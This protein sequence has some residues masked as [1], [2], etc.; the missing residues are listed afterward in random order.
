ML[1]YLVP[2]GWSSWSVAK[3]CSVSC[4][5][6]IEILTRTCTN[7][8]PQ[9]GGKSCPRE[10][11][12]QQACSKNPCPSMFSL[13]NI[14]PRFFCEFHAKRLSGMRFSLMAMHTGSN[15]PFARSGH[16]VRNKLCWD[17]NNAMGLSNK[18][19][20]LDW[21]EFLCFGSLS[22]LFVS[23]HNLIRTM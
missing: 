23:Q 18:G 14:T 20:S 2:G 22:A 10:A 21:Y 8:A 5:S 16:M 1:Y 17:A 6:G 3:P 12:K 15:R 9:H 11:Q 19:K 7:P 4:G 13:F